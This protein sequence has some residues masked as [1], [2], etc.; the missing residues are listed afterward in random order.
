M[1]RNLKPVLIAGAGPTKHMFTGLRMLLACSLRLSGVLCLMAAC[2][3]PADAP[4]TVGPEVDVM[5]LQ[6]LR[7]ALTREVPGRTSVLLSA[8]VRPQVT[9]FILRR[10]FKEGTDVRAG[11][12]L[13]EIDPRTYQVAFNS[14]KASLSLAE[15]ILLKARVG[16]WPP[17]S[18]NTIKQQGDNADAEYEYAQK[19][20]ATAR[21]ALDKARI[22]LA[23]TRV[24]APISGRIGLS[25]VTT[26][27]VVGANQPNALA[28]VLQIDP[29]YVDV[30]A[31]STDILGLGQQLSSGEQRQADVATGAVS[32]QLSDGSVYSC[33]GKLQVSE[34]HTLAGT[35][36]VSVRAVFRNPKGLLLPGMAVRLQVQD[37]VRD[38]ALLVPQRSVMRD[39]T[40]QARVLVLGTNN[41]VEAR[42]VTIER[43]VGDQWL[44]GAGVRAGE[45]IVLGGFERIHPG[46]VI[47]PVPSPRNAPKAAGEPGGRVRQLRLLTV[48][49]ALAARPA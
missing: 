14:A 37:G 9:G 20:V 2:S 24:R 6:P 16:T 41:R 31:S 15:A 36:S 43:M 30:T 42:P 29:I 17:G 11:Q 38:Q 40:G 26:G 10:D 49:G 25:T 7:I 33:T 46:I 28:T 8:E 45:R 35:G 34:V 3:G 18:P 4:Q 21:A 22:E 23:A 5:T 27:D 44:I 39:T 13:Y 47:T 19:D 32:L 12:V 1:N 48:A